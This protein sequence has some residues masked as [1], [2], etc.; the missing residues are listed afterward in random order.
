MRA[1]SGGAA[2]PPKDCRR[3]RA[4]AAGAGSGGPLFIP[5]NDSSSA[6]PL[7][8]LRGESPPL[9]IAPPLVP[10]RLGLGLGL[11]LG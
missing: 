7:P 11:G 2:T 1:L 3:G 6:L 4:F 9:D 10:G 5:P 8:L